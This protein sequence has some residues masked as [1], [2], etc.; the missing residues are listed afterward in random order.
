[1]S[2]RRPRLAALVLLGL[3]LAAC[4]KK[5]PP[6]I[7]ENRLPAPAA[8]LGALID[9]GAIQVSWTNP[10]TRFDG[11]SLRDLIEV[12]LYRREDNDD[13]PLKP[14]MLSGGQVVGKT[15]RY[16]LDHGKE[17][18]D[19]SLDEF[20]QASSH[21]DRDVY[22]AITV[23]ASLRARGVIG[24]TAPEA[25]KRQLAEAKALVARETRS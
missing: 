16:A 1:M 9:E 18:A 24:G 3:A 11:T 14:A 6:V 15:V 4:G 13:S 7:P 5:G 23:E 17:L 22:E 19:L 21:I 10:T 8:G 20:R 25:V 12:K 2:R